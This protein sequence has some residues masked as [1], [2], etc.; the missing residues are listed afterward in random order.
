MTLTLYYFHDP[1]CSWCWAFRPRWQEITA[2][3]PDSVGYRRVLGGLAPDTDQAMPKE[4]QAKLRAI[5]QTIQQTVPSTPF[6]FE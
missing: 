2:G 3:L 1:M 6:N 4:M 5:W